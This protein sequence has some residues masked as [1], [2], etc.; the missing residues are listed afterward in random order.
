MLRNPKFDHFTK[1]CGL[2]HLEIWQMTLKIWE[3]QV[4]GVSND[5][6]KYHGNLWWNML[7]KAG[8]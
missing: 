7:T 2:C 4:V 8:R 5:V 6:E 1:F 3:P